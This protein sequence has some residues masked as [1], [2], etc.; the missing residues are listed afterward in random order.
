MTVAL[1]FFIAGPRRA[2]YIGLAVL[3]AL[4]LA[5]NGLNLVNSYVGRYFMNALGERN[6]SK[7]YLFAE[8]LALVFAASTAA[9]VLATYIQ[10]RLGLLWRDWLTRRLLN[11]YLADRAY[12]RMSAHAD[13]DNPDQRI[14]EDVHTFCESTLGFLVLLFNA[15]LTL[16]AFAGVLWSIRPSLFL[17]AAA[18]AALGSLGTILLGRPLV[19]LDN[20]QLKKEADFRFALGRV[21][22][23]AGAVAQLGGEED[24]SARLCGRLEALV[25]NFRAIINVSRNLGF[26]T[27][28][29]NFLPQIIP[30]MLAA[31]LYIRG[32]VELGAVTQA[33]MAFSQVLGAF[34]LI[35]TQFQALSAYTAVVGRLGTLWEATAPTAQ[36]PA[37]VAAPLV[38]AESSS[39]APGAAA[40]AAKP[41]GHR[42]AYDRLTLLTPEEGRPLVRALSLEVTEGKRVLVRGPSG[43]GKSALLLATAGLWQSGEGQV[44]CPGNGEVMFLPKQPY[45]APGRLRDL[46]RYG[47]HREI[48]DAR[49]RV[50]LREVGLQ[51]LADRPG[52]LDA[53]RDWAQVLSPGEL[54]LV[55]FARLLAVAP[56]FAFLDDPASALDAAGINRVYESLARSAITY[57]SVAG[58]VDLRRFHDLILDLHGDGSWQVRPGSS[59]SA[60]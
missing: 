57:V 34:S 55:A 26:F 28:M 23:H 24:E 38:V 60:A 14:S 58:H 6:L 50:A 27:T 30:I 59:P 8:A 37:P 47:T 46:L 51:T 40:V 52:G 11:R 19:K 2:A 43:S 12:H 22:E 29:Y 18:Y 13:V 5:V 36:A 4:L 53:E 9:Q 21:R 56:K 41:E 7:F 49:L 42:V 54:E 44:I 3:I 31:P 25:S 39:P 32:E 10:Q 16:I 15:L 33:A 20:L 45:A 1:P 35:V 17:A 48:P